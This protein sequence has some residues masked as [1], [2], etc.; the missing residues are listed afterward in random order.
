MPKILYAVSESSYFAAS[1]VLGDSGG[2]SAFTPE[3][4]NAISLLCLRLFSTIGGLFVGLYGIASMI[5]GYLIFRSPYLPKVIGVLLVIGGAGFF[6]RTATFL[7]APSY[8]SP[9]LL[10]PMA[11]AG[12]PLTFWLLLRGVKPIG[13]TPRA[14]S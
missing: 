6:L 9:A 2:M 14:A 3:Q 11:L 4:R 12:I 7:L 10:A 5:R 8:S 13:S 1:M